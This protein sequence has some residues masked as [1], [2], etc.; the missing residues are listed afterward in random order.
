MSP[1]VD[2]CRCNS[3]MSYTLIRG[4]MGINADQPAVVTYEKGWHR[5]ENRN[6]KKSWR[7]IAHSH[8]GVSLYMRVPYALALNTS[9]CDL[10]RIAN[11]YTDH[12]LN[13]AM[14][15]SMS[16]YIQHIKTL[17]QVCKGWEYAIRAKPGTDVWM[18][19]ITL[20][21][22]YAMSRRVLYKFPIYEG[23]I[24]GEI[25][26]NIVDWADT[27]HNRKRSDRSIFVQ[28]Y[29]G[30]DGYVRIIFE[31]ETKDV[32]DR[33][34]D[35]LRDH[36]MNWIGDS[37]TIT[38]RKMSRVK[39]LREFTQFVTECPYISNVTIYGSA[40]VNHQF[41]VGYE[42][43]RNIAPYMN[44]LLSDT[45]IA[46]LMAGPPADNVTYDDDGDGNEVVFCPHITK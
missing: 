38:I 36:N 15:T 46:I 33:V 35:W 7:R 34:Y 39:P 27:Y 29:D 10:S 14:P 24:G 4:R 32:R 31:I 25:T 6:P 2:I 26:R 42:I 43:H 8:N 22:T 28:L 16:K 18:D 37:P 1:P 41:D 23:K 40:W 45:Q 13:G 11:V 12:A 20:I 9:Y 30:K 44:M 17:H 19:P 21:W 5:S 3:A